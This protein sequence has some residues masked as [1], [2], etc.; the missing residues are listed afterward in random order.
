MEAE[1]E[2]ELVTL[3]CGRQ[4]LGINRLIDRPAVETIPFLEIAHNLY[5]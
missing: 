2:T 3:V 4:Q 1:Q 5:K